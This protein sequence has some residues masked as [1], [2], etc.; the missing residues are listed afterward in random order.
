MGI[1]NKETEAANKEARISSKETEAAN[2]EEEAGI[3]GKETE[4][5]NKEVE[6]FQTG[7]RKR[8]RYLT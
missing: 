3:G 5:A 6:K 2:K 8:K 4:A 1:S 7:T